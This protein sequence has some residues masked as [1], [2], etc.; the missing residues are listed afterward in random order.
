M[1]N[2]SV[3]PDGQLERYRDYLRMLARGQVGTRLQG[4]IDSSDLVQQTL[5][6]AY[7][8][9]RHFR[10]QSESEL[11]SWLRQILAHSLA[12]ALRRFSAGAR[13][14]TLE[15][16]LEVLLDESSSRLEA[17]LAAD[18]PSP[19]V[20]AQ[21]NEQLLLLANAMAQL[22]SDQVQAI[23]LH[24]LR[25]LPLQEVAIEMGRSKRAVAGLLFRAMRQIRSLIQRE[26]QCNDH[27]RS[28]NGN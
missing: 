3:M 13:D 21:R 11:A 6:Q 8:S 10:G 15:R 5:L 9:R 27:G 19:P 7:C 26:L 22:P 1:A 4:K 16:S 24:H 18:E 28:T 14:V 20:I 12:D 2:Q 23:E 17:W 25:G